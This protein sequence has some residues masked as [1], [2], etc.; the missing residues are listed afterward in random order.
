MEKDKKFLQVNRKGFDPC[1]AV[2]AGSFCAGLFS[3]F[4]FGKMGLLVFG[5]CVLLGLITEGIKK[6]LGYI[7]AVVIVLVTALAGKTELI[8]GLKAFSNEISEAYGKTYGRIFPLFEGVEASQQ[9]KIILTIAVSS[10]T[11]ILAG[12]IM[13]IAGRGVAL[14]GIVC[15]LL[16]VSTLKADCNMWIAAAIVSG[17]VLAGR[18]TGTFRTAVSLVLAGA[19]VIGMVS[20]IG[21]VNISKDGQALAFTKSDEI[22][23]TVTME[24]PQSMYLKGETY[25]LYKDGLWTDFS[26]EK[27]YENRDLFYWLHEEDFY[28]QSQLAKAALTFDANLMVQANQVTV[29]I[30]RADDSVCYVPYEL[31][32]GK[33]ADKSAIGDGE[34]DCSINGNKSYQFTALPNQVKSYAGILTNITM[35]NAKVADGKEMS[36]DAKKY[37]NQ[38]KHYNN[39][40]YSNYLELSED[41]RSML[42]GM[43]GKYKLD[44]KSHYDYLKSKEKIVN[45]LSGHI[46]YDEEA[47]YE[48]DF[49]DDFLSTSCKG[50]SVHYASA[51]VLMMRYYGIPA[52]LASG[53][54]VT[55]AD[56]KNMDADQ[57]YNITEENRHYWV[58]YYQDGVG[59]IPFE[60]TTP[61]IGIMESENHLASV[62][63]KPKD[64]PEEKH[65]MTQDNYKKPDKVKKEKEHLRLNGTKVIIIALLAVMLIMVILI[66]LYYI[67]RKKTFD[68]RYKQ[69]YLNE[70]INRRSVFH[71]MLLREIDGRYGER[72]KNPD[73]YN[74]YQKARYSER[75]IKEDEYVS[76][77]SHINEQKTLIYQSRTTLQKLAWKY[78]WFY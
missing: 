28:G 5:I 56:E 39:Y 58:E 20:L 15:L 61:Y 55:P 29:D 36:K 12:L 77:D 76:L 47:A 51:G 53:Y 63:Q 16:V 66:A 9:D 8:A 46:T 33:L 71:Y 62:N 64:E 25:D 42:E 1:K 57:P 30:E 3:M 72:E 44:G 24:T 21:D 10:I 6:P 32:D 13:D 48:G 26:G 59:W 50:Y 4:G 54:L 45:F 68:E 73:A 49:I 19:I 17:A 43:L 67:R 65:E 78:W 14:A 18:K 22:A 41:Q 74:I 27:L 70:N 40:I 37:L 52:R 23:M 69:G 31:A 7:P 75:G 35:E 11:V 38:E 34:I 2:F 60:V